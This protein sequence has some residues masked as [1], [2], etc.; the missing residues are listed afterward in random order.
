MIL[1]SLSSRVQAASE[2]RIAI[3]RGSEGKKRRDTHTHAHTETDSF[4]K[5]V[6]VKIYT[7][8]RGNHRNGR[9]YKRKKAISFYVTKL[10]SP[11]I[12]LLFIQHSL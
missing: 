1:N 9:V 5:K 10:A 4:L 3:S 6:M 2:T 12:H 8:E 11:P 7:A